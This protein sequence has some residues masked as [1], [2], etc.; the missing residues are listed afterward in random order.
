[1]DIVFAVLNSGILDE[2]NKVLRESSASR[3]KIAERDDWKAL[4]MP[5]KCKL[6]IL[7][8]EFSAQQMAA[9]RKGHIPQEMEDKWFWFME[10]D[11]LYAHRSWTGICIYRIEF[12]ADGNHAV[13]VNRDPEQ[14]SFTSIDEDIAQITAKPPQPGVPE[15]RLFV[16][17]FK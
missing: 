5:E 16:I 12:K 17:L 15:R 7:K 9:L 11:N 6:F 1:M 2:G 13:T 14:Y 10:A 4:D 3:Y 8:R